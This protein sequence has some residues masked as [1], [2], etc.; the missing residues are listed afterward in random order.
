MCF[1]QGLSSVLINRALFV[2]VTVLGLAGVLHLR[3]VDG[4]FLSAELAIVLIVGIAE[5][6]VALVIQIIAA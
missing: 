6:T 1:F 2:L 3:I 5:Q 4:K